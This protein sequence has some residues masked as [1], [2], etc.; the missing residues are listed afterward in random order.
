MGELIWFLLVQIFRL[1]FGLRSGLRRTAKQSIRKVISPQT[2]HD[3]FDLQQEQP[4]Q[5]RTG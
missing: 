5:G 3:I 2:R 1:S 4:E